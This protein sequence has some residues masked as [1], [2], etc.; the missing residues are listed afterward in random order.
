MGGVHLDPENK[1]NR[2]QPRRG[3][4][5]LFN[6]E[7]YKRRLI[8]ER[9]FAWIDKFRALRSAF[10]A[11]LPVGSALTILPLRSL[12]YAIFWLYEFESVQVPGLGTSARADRPDRLVCRR[13]Q[14]GLDH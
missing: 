4:K 6:A 2:K 5:R 8:S 10:T 3:R 1:R 7:T 11:R 12:T 14:A 9:S 13:N